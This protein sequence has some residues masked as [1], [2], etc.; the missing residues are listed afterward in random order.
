MLDF[1]KIK[2]LEKKQIVQKAINLHIQGNIQEAVNVYEYLINQGL[3]D[4]LVFSNYGLILKNHGRLKDAER[5][6]RKAIKSNIN[7]ANAHYN[8]GLTLSLLGRE[9]EAF[10][11]L[12]KVNEIDPSTPNINLS[13]VDLISNSDISKFNRINLGKILNI[14]MNKEDIPHQFLFNAINSL[15]IL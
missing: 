5:F 12:I 10:N 6:L 4:P 9:S 2:K 15:S 11:C 14:L 7:C 1:N 13:L 3:N 8:L